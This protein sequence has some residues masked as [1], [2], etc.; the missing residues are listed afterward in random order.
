MLGIGEAMECPPPRGCGGDPVTP[1]VGEDGATRDEKKN[2][3]HRSPAD[4]V[5]ALDHEVT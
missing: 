5:E 2:E 1:E 4:T 3:V